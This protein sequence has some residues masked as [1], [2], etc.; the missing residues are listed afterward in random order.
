MRAVSDWMKSNF[1]MSPFWYV[2]KP[3]RFALAVKIIGDKTSSGNKI[4]HNQAFQ[5]K[6]NGGKMKMVVHVYQMWH[7]LAS[8]DSVASAANRAQEEA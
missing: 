4:H 3:E 8:L 1:T 6:D 7:V 2:C 5:S